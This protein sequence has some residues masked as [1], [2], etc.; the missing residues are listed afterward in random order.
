M[1][2]FNFLIT[3]SV[4]SSIFIGLAFLSAVVTGAVYS[5]TCCDTRAIDHELNIPTPEQ[6]RTTRHRPRL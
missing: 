5:L 4:F 3:A 2:A 6:D 1:R